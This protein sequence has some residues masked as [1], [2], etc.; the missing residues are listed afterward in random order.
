MTIIGPIAKV[1]ATQDVRSTGDS[2]RIRNAVFEDYGRIAALQARNGL[3]VKSYEDWRALW[4][5]NPIY[6]QKGGDWPIGWVLE[7]TRGE[8]VGSISN[9]PLAYQFQGRELLTVTS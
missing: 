9:I 4:G 7:T 1:D 8:I 6:K 2:P 3:A 5:A